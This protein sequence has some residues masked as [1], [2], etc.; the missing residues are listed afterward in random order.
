MLILWEPRLAFLATPK[1]GSTSV[2]KA[3]SPFAAL[4][5]T[6][7][8]LLK[9]TRLHRY[10]RFI[11]PYLRAASGEDF[12]TVA[13]IREPRDW[14]GSWFRYR[15][16]EGVDPEKSTAAMS[17]EDF[18]RAYAAKDRPAFADLGS[19]AHF[20]R[21]KDRQVDHLFRHD[22]MSAL[23]AF[24][25]ERLNQRLE[26]PR[27]NVS[28]PGDLSLTPEAEALLRATLAEDYEIYESCA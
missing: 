14:V 10:Q 25:E 13:L 12:A 17:F 19:Q 3:L 4:K 21:P 9:H 18:V 11:A 1:T 28:P 24:L 8:P 5:T 15:R 6:R 20:L 23:V 22:N 26:L 2:Q 16:R 27:M 7:P